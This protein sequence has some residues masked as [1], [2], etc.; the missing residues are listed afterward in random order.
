MSHLP[1]PWSHLSGTKHTWSNQ[2]GLARSNPTQPVGVLR[3]YVHFASLFYII[4]YCYSLIYFIFRSDTYVVSFFYM[5]D[6]HRRTCCRSQD[7]A[8]KW[9]V[10]SPYFWRPTILGKYPEI[11][12]LPEDESSQKEGAKGAPGGPHHHVA[13]ASPCL[14]HPGVRLPWPSSAIAPS[15][16]LSSLKT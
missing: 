3:W 5:F 16:I 1:A 10:K 12:I 6:D 9:T 14:R 8:G 4:I 2:T 13:W 7:S 15:R 11:H